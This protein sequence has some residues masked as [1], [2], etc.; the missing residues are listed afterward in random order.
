MQMFSELHGKKFI[1]E[2]ND[3]IEK[4]KSL[5]TK[6]IVKIPNNLEE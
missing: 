3:L 2:I 5:G 6:V 4:D 1:Y